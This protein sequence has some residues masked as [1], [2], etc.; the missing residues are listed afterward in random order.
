MGNAWKL[1]ALA[2][3]FAASGLLL[4]ADLIVEL[5]MDVWHLQLCRLAEV[6]LHHVKEAV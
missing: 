6:A 1:A 3:R 5:W 4:E 2:L